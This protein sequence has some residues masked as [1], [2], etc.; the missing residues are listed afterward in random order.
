MI[1]GVLSIENLKRSKWAHL[2]SDLAQPFCQVSDQT[3]K[4]CSRNGVRASFRNAREIT[5]RYGTAVTMREGPVDGYALENHEVVG[6]RLCEV[7]ED[8]Q[9]IGS[10]RVGRPHGWSRANARR[11]L[12][13]ARRC[14]V[15]RKRWYGSRAAGPTAMTR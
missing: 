3:H 15:R 5:G 14:K 7:V 8:R 11:A 6:N 1:H 4:Q 9:G 10:G 12:S 2:Q 13:T